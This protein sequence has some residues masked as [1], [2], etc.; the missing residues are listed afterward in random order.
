MPLLSFSLW[1][2]WPL[3]SDVLSLAAA[4]ASLLVLV[5]STKTDFLLGFLI[6]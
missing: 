6:K 5:N 1:Q 3:L 4:E 2:L